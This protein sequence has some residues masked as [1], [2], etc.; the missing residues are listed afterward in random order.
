MR[1]VCFCSIIVFCAFAAISRAGLQESDSSNFSF[2]LSP[3]NQTIA[4]SQ[5][6]TQGGA[7][8]LNWVK[9][10]LVANIQ[11]NITGEND[12][13]IAGNMQLSLTGLVDADAPTI[14]AGAGISENS[15]MVSVSATDGVADSG[16]DFHN[17]GT[18]GG[19]DTDNAVELS[20]F[21]AYI[22][23]GTF[24]VNIVGSGGFALSGVTDSTLKISN[25]GTNGTVTV[26]Y[27]YDVVPEPAT[28]ALLALG[29]LPVLLRK[30]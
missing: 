3:G 22:G 28:L 4:L 11:A 15:A 7:R 27:D 13:T 8:V 6:D 16:P 20:S 19:S 5:F 21:S 25:F 24:N 30:R 12:S 1:R 29:G 23:T 10:T 9:I 17:F 26:L 18:F 14:S 2:P